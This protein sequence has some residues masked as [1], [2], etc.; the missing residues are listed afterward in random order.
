MSVVR[1][2]PRPPE[3]KANFY[4]LAL[5]FLDFPHATRRSGMFCVCQATSQIRDNGRI[6]RRFDSGLLS[7]LKK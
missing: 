1:F 6:S 4:R 5:S 3:F 2:R 7:V